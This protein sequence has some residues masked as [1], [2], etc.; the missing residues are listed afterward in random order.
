M[1]NSMIRC[2]HHD[3]QGIQPR[4]AVACPLGAA[5][6]LDEANLALFDVVADSQP[7]ASRG[8]NWFIRRFG[9]GYP[10]FEGVVH[11]LQKHLAQP[12][13]CP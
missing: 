11:L 5:Q 3:F 12:T 8:G 1:G 7:I 6:E 4:L 9:A 10:D 2:A 13:A